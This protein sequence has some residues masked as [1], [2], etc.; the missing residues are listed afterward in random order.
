MKPGIDTVGKQIWLCL[1]F[2]LP[3]SLSI[4][5]PV[6]SG[7]MTL[8]LA[9]LNLHAFVYSVPSAWWTL[10]NVHVS[11]HLWP[12][13][14]L[15]FSSK[16]TSFNK[17]LC[18]LEELEKRIFNGLTTKKWEVHEMMG[19]LTTFNC[20]SERYLTFKLYSISV[21]NYKILIKNK[22]KISNEPLIDSKRKPPPLIFLSFFLFSYIIPTL[23]LHCNAFYKVMIIIRIFS[24]W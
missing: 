18:I 21:Y 8:F 9:V 23:L 1:P 6:S 3:L 7:Q 15:N 17:V 12:L 4:Y 19:R 22:L 14:R 20:Q 5:L 11:T 16:V 13:H 2:Y 10:S 24:Q